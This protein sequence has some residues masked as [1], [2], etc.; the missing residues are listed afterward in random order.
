[1]S[2]PPLT[3]ERVRRKL[4][5]VVGRQVLRTS[6]PTAGRR[7]WLK[8]KG[9]PHLRYTEPRAFRHAAAALTYSEAEQLRLEFHRRD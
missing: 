6:G 2:G 5:L 4:L 1:M 7:V 8:C 3:P 9:R